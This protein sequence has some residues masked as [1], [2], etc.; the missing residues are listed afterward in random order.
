M[1]ICTILYDKTVKTA[2]KFQINYEILIKIYKWWSK[3]S[4]K[5]AYFKDKFFS[6]RLTPFIFK[7]KCSKSIKT[8][9]ALHN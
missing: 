1:K 6:L 7:T 3:K 9:N 4:K 8:Q 5:K 2:K